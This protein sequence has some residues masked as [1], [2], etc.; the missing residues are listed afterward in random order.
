MSKPFVYGVA[1]EDRGRD[2]VE[3][4]IGMEPTGDPFNAI[5]LEPGT[6]RPLN[7][8]INAGAI[9]GASLVAGDTDAARL[10]RVLDT[11]SAF[12]GRPLD[13]ARRRNRR[14]VSA[15]AEGIRGGRALTPRGF[16]TT[17]GDQ[18][19]TTEDAE[20]TEKPRGPLCDLRALR[21]GDCTGQV[22]PR[23]TITPCDQSPPTASWDSTR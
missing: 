20:N 3:Q 23:T 1:L 2:R 17:R 7:P 12:A 16:L 8:M 9:A 18:R 22:Q 10:A 21:G 14:S 15:A 5:S 4:A 11:L 13:A 19:A 6:G